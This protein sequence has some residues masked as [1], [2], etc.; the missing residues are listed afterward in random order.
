LLALWNTARASSLAYEIPSG[1][2]AET[3]QQ[4]CAGRG[5]H[6]LESDSEPTAEQINKP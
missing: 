4:V 3:V 2:E 5:P 6:A 1:I